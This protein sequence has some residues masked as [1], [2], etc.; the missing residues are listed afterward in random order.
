M[1]EKIRHDTNT[2]AD[3]KSILSHSITHGYNNEQSFYN[4]FQ[5]GGLFL[6]SFLS[7]LK[8]LMLLDKPS[9]DLYMYLW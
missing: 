9:P 4:K 3:Y 6:P 2:R 5:V 7:A 1:T 8:H